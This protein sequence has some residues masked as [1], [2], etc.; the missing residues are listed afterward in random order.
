MTDTRK[1]LCVVFDIDETLIQFI[2]KNQL[3]NIKWKTMNEEDKS[4]FTFVEK[5]NGHIIFI[6][7][8]LKD[9]FRWFKTRNIKIGLWTYSE[10]EYAEDIANILKH[11]CDVDDDFFLFKWGAEQMD[12]EEFPKNLSVVWDTYPDLSTFNTFIVDDLSGN[13]KHDHNA[14]NCILIQPYAPFGRNKTRRPMDNELRNRALEDNALD[15]LK[16]VCEKVIN[17]IEGCDTEDIDGSFD[18]E[19]VF[20]PHRLNRMG[21]SPLLKK[22]ATKFIT[23]PAIGESYQTNKFI[24]VTEQSEKYGDPIKGGRRRTKKS[25]RRTNSR[26]RRTKPKRTCKRRKA[27]KNPDGSWNKKDLESNQKCYDKYVFLDNPWM[28][29]KQKGVKRKTKRRTK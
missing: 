8:F 22:Y 11:E 15:Q 4:G 1:Q 10:Q 3:T 23:L 2:N 17:D 12:D 16:T 9:L 25:K 20:S 5:S 24:D 7:P 26:T 28:K 18:T 21:L 19:A 29:K 27:R 14:Q 6:R 13:I